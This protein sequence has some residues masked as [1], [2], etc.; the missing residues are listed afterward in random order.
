MNITFN[1]DAKLVI[2]GVDFDIAPKN[3]LKVILEIAKIERGAMLFRP[4]YKN[5]KEED[6]DAVAKFLVTEIKKNQEYDGT[7][8]SNTQ[9]EILSILGFLPSV[10]VQKTIYGL[11]AKTAAHILDGYVYSITGLNIL[12]LEKVIDL[13]SLVK[14]R[15][16]FTQYGRC[17]ELSFVHLIDILKSLAVRINLC[18]VI[19]LN[20]T[21]RVINYCTMDREREDFGEKVYRDLTEIEKYAITEML[22]D[23]SI[24]TLTSKIAIWSCGRLRA[25]TLNMSAFS[26]RQKML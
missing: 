12:E 2:G 1:K 4:L 13:D 7:F 10:V 18:D 8:S 9:Y 22:T 17:K 15:D 20:T 3:E 16:I 11:D 21:A 25:V 23:K 5:Q 19:D 26:E 24:T 6:L 14:T